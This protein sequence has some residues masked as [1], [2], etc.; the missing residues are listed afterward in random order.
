MQWLVNASRLFLTWAVVSGPPPRRP[1][2]SC[3]CT[4][5]TGCAGHTPGC[6][7]P[8]STGWASTFLWNLEHTHTQTDAHS[9]GH[10]HFKRFYCDTLSPNSLKKEHSTMCISFDLATEQKQSNKD[11]HGDFS[12]YL[13]STVRSSARCWS[14]KP[15]RSGATPT[16]SPAAWRAVLKSGIDTCP[17]PG[18]PLGR[19]WRMQ[20]PASKRQTR[21]RLLAFIT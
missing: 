7:S 1:G 16:G 8:V 4:Y 18:S 10:S 15:W 9:Y 12:P 3:L 17:G 21:D 13:L 6:W 14:W 20:H 2:G 19:L 5:E 11:A